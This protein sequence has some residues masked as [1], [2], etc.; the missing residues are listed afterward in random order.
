MM[1]QKA[2][3]EQPQ[4]LPTYSTSNITTLARKLSGKTTTFVVGYCVSVRRLAAFSH[5]CTSSQHHTTKPPCIRKTLSLVKA[6]HRSGCSRRFQSLPHKVLDI[7]LSS[8]TRAYVTRTLERTHTNRH[9]PTLFAR[10]RRRSG[11]AYCVVSRFA[12]CAG[13]AAAVR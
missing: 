9:T 1:F 5:A 6:S 8:V 10:R 3:H 4:S 11:F 7:A 12:C 13:A 2:Y